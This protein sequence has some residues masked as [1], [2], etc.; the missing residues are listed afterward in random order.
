[1][2]GRLGLSAFD[3]D[4][5]QNGA[6]ISMVVA[7]IA[8]LAVITY[9]KK[10]K[11][12]WREYLT[13]VDPKRIGVMYM[14]V[15][16][17]MFAKGFSDA[18]LM[19]TQQALAVGD[20]QGILHAQHFQEIFSAHGTAM[21]FFVAMGFVFGL[22][23]LIVPLQIGARDVAYPFLNALAFWLFT[24]GGMLTL[25]SLAIGHF[26]ISGWLYGLHW[27]RV[28]E[29][30]GFTKQEQILVR[31]Q[32]QIETLTEKNE[33][34]NAALR[35]EEADSSEAGPGAA[36]AESPEAVPSPVP[37]SPVPTSPVPTSPVPTYSEAS[38]RAGS[39]EPL[40]RREEAGEADG[41]DP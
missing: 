33:Q 4:A 24:A 35:E 23:N 30:T 34:L 39:G 22:L 17:I 41:E 3:H 11:W 13:S 6:V 1:M 14:V 12:L 8:I 7:G 36:E 31:L 38:D 2:F 16:L 5:I 27:K 32:D 29:G 25:I 40:D 37:T 28:A 19:R 20:S 9:L 26:S 10:W 18:V 15:M 21:I